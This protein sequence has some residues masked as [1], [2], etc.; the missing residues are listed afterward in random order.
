MI[1]ASAGAVDAH[2]HVLSAGGNGIAGAA[3]RPFAAPVADFLAHLDALGFA[4]GVLVNPSVYGSDH[5]ELLAA[6]RAHPDRLRG[7]AVVPSDVDDDT[8]DELHAAGVRGCRVQDRLAGGQPIAE[9]PEIARRVAGR[10]WHV[11]VWTDLAEH[12]AVVRSVLETATTPI[13]LDHLGNIPAG[14]RG[15]GLLLELLAAGPCWVTLSGAYRLAPGMP[16]AAA[17]RLLRDRV[18]AVLAAAPDRVLWGSD[19]P[20]VA[21]PGPVPTAAEHAAVLDDWLGDAELR[22][23]VL[24]TNPAER[25][26][27]DVLE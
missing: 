20:Y 11:E 25:Y 18:E 19:W 6:L 5:T 24:V 4:R 14:E 23:R 7:V 15:T 12:A 8:L 21:P 27:W 10:G 16:E 26:G 2:A 13:V 1:E 22:T 17:A 9:L 3:Y